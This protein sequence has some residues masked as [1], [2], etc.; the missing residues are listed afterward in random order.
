VRL[1]VE[2]LIAVNTDLGREFDRAQVEYAVTGDLS[3]LERMDAALEGLRVNSRRLRLLVEG[4][5]S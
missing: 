2:E 3:G 5:A 1:Q 4:G